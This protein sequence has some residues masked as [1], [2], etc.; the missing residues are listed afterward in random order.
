MMVKMRELART[1][2]GF[3]FS[4]KGRR[5]QIAN[6]ANLSDEFFELM[7][8]ACDTYPDIAAAGQITGAE[9]R[10]A[11]TAARSYKAVAT[12]MQTQAKGLDDTATE[13]RAGVGRRCLNAYQI[14]KRL[15]KQEHRQTLIPHLSAIKRALNKGR[16]PK[17]KPEE[18]EL[19]A[20]AKKEK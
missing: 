20:A 6:Y 15:E 12:D 10:T 19:A 8:V 7:A 9:I 2:E 4:G 3:N 11:I 18:G 13:V 17:K 14:A 5:V 1:I 16:P